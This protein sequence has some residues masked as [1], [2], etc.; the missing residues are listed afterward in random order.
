MKL[1][2]G[3]EEVLPIPYLHLLKIGR[4]LL[5]G[6]AS[7]LTCLGEFL[8]AYI[9]GVLSM[10]CRVG[11]I[12]CS[13]TRTPE[14][15]ALNLRTMLTLLLLNL[16]IDTAQVLF[17]TQLSSWCYFRRINICQFFFASQLLL[18]LGDIIVLFR[19]YCHSNVCADWW[20]NAHVV[21]SLIFKQRRFCF[22]SFLKMVPGANVWD[23][24]CSIFLTRY[25]M[26]VP[27]NK[28]PIKW[29]LLP[30]E[31][32]T[33]RNSV[34]CNLRQLPKQYLLWP[35]RHLEIWIAS[36]GPFLLAKA[37]NGCAALVAPSVCEY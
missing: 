23:K 6:L 32:N 3:T 8:E 24:E 4:G 34:F 20:S 12:I 25:D 19:C 9:F 17:I 14:L 11:F 18:L 27:P 26:G 36:R 33:Q 28:R 2:E 5:F 37:L 1:R 35:S 16:Y 31:M 21:F 13:P 22:I 30:R 29:M 15:W 10:F 7:S